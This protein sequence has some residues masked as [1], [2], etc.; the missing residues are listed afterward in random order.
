MN[1][2]TFITSVLSAVAAGAMLDVDQFLWEPGAKAIFLP[3]ARPLIVIPRLVRGDMFTIAGEYARNPVTGLVTPHLQ[4]FVVTADVCASDRELSLYPRI[5]G[6]AI[7]R[8]RGQVT[9][10]G[11]ATSRAV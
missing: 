1:R 8:P 9:S 2:R 10:G 6:Q 4:Y 3:P 11:W 7:V 5:D